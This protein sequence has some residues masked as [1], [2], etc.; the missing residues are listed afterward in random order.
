VGRGCGGHSSCSCR[1]TY[2]MISALS[3]CVFT[4]L[5]IDSPVS[6]RRFIPLVARI[7]A[8]LSSPS[9]DLLNELPMSLSVRTSGGGRYQR[10]VGSDVGRAANQLRSEL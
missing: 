3:A 6:E 5:P 7:F 1:Q 9:G 8:G 4:F 2:I 10:L